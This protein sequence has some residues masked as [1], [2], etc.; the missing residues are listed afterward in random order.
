MY[1]E[2]NGMVCS[3]FGN[4]EAAKF[5]SQGLNAVTRNFDPPEKSKP[6]IV[7]DK[8]VA[9][10]AI[11]II[12]EPVVMLSEESKKSFK[13]LVL[14]LADSYELENMD[15][16]KGIATFKNFKIIWGFMS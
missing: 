8:A 16:S 13:K 6:V 5:F 4:G 11:N 12:E 7:G 15:V 2:K 9:V 1:N 10:P 14:D 3:P